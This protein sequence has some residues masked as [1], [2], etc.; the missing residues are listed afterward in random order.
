[1]PLPGLH[2]P[3]LNSL[4]SLFYSLHLT[5]FSRGVA[6]SFIHLEEI[7]HNIIVSFAFFEL[8]QFKS[9]T[10]YDDSLLDFSWQ[11]SDFLASLKFGMIHEITQF[12]HD[13]FILNVIDILIRFEL[14]PFVFV[15]WF[16]VRFIVVFQHNFVGNLR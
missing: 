6:H 8:L 5:E 4:S 13:K 10:L 16:S 1:M 12:K 14:C 15:F 9:V 3:L 7:V 11:L 2:I